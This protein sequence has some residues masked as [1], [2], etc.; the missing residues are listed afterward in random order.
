[1]TIRRL[2][3]LTA[4]LFTAVTISAIV[5]I[6]QQSVTL[7]RTLTRQQEFQSLVQGLGYGASLDLAQCEFGFDP[8]LR[9]CCS[10]REGPIPGGFFLC[11]R[12]DGGVAPVLRLPP[13]GTSDADVDDHAAPR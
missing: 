1:M 7:D 11:S 6:V 4:V 12:H 3:R 13:A 9:S 10:Q 8:R 5:V 2:R